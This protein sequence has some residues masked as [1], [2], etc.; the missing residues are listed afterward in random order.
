MDAKKMRGGVLRAGMIV[1]VFLVALLS[2]QGCWNLPLDGLYP[3]NDLG[4][5][6]NKEGATGVKSDLL[7]FAQVT[8]VHIVDE[9]NPLRL[10]NIRLWINSPY[11]FGDLDGL[12]Q[13]ISRDQ[14]IYS[15]RIW[16]AVV[17]SI[18]EGHEERPF[19]FTMSTGDH[20]DTG[21]KSEM[22]WFIGITDGIIPDSL[23]EAMEDGS[24]AAVEPAG[25]NVPWYAALGNHDVEYQGTI[26]NETV[27][28]CLLQPFGDT[29]NLINMRSA[30]D[31]YQETFSAPWWHGMAEQPPSMTA[32]SYGYYAFNAGEYVRCIVLNTAIYNFYGKI[33]KETLSA[34]CL[35]RNQYGWMLGEIEANRDRLCI[36]FSHHSPTDGFDDSQSDISAK[37]LMKTLCLYDNVIAHING[38]S[39]VNKIVPVKYRGLPGGYWN[40]NTGAIIEWPQE[41]RD[42]TIRD[43]G[44]GTGSLSCRMV[45]HGDDGCLDIAYGDADA[46]HSAR[47]GEKTD[48]DVALRFRVPA[49]VQTRIASF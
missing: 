22:E 29:G 27:V 33:P 16:D 14:D 31:L 20:T 5:R 36:I 24:M 34:G 8:D 11:D 9:D 30:V 46:R 2:L 41:W 48:R 21:L 4:A 39:H 26:N 47:E 35:D 1:P 17:R 10:E 45:R 32:D 15:G 37:E 7:H 28:K 6:P 49:A 3:R 42:I 23:M 12:I 44:D 43:N 25:L 40:I 19:E 38:H 18:N 13:P